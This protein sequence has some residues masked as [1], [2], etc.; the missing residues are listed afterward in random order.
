V[1]Q[2]FLS[3]LLLDEPPAVSDAAV[4]TSAAPSLV[5]M[6]CAH[7]VTAAEKTVLLSC[8]ALLL[9]AHPLLSASPV[10]ATNVSF[11]FDHVPSSLLPS[12]ADPADGPPTAPVFLHASP[13]LL[14]LSAHID[15]AAIA[16]WDEFVA[17][18]GQC[19]L[20]SAAVHHCD[21]HYPPSSGAL[22]PVH[23][24]L[25]LLRLP[26]PVH[27][28]STTSAASHQQLQQIR[29]HE[30]MFVLVAL[31]ARVVTAYDQSRAPHAAPTQ[32][33]SEDASGF[34]IPSSGSPDAPI[35]PTTLYD[36]CIA[37]FQFIVEHQVGHVRAADLALE[38]TLQRLSHYCMHIDFIHPDSPI[39]GPNSRQTTVFLARTVAA[40]LL[41]PTVTPLS[42]QL[43]FLLKFLKTW[44]GG[45]F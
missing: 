42:S 39:V 15:P 28:A 8:L 3:L 44:I 5:A 33:G 17:S 45:S 24:A 14:P 31:M 18:L 26:P 29:C 9:V 36:A 35:P 21:L 10:L 1:R 40:L 34:L 23:F 38:P 43:L 4:D 20:L 11:S 37:D 41:A 32:H 7:D 13:L 25:D 30:A 6:C 19:I 12:A 22:S 27:V 16:F 2:T